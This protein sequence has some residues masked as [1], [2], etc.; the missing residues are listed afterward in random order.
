MCESHAFLR[1]GEKERLILEDVVNIREEAGKVHLTSIIGEEQTLDAE[2][3]EI[4]LLNHR[5]LLAPH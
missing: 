3:A 1:E 2:I 4:D 5:I